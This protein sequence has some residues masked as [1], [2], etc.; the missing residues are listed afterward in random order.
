MLDT[1]LRLLHAL[2]HVVLTTSHVLSA[3]I[4]SIFIGYGGEQDAQAQMTV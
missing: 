3:I 4:I 2:I 1:V